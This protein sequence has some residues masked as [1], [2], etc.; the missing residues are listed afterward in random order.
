MGTDEQRDMTN[1]WSL[2]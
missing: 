1:W 2:S